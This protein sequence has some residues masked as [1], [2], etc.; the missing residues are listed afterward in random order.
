MPA[1]DPKSAPA[2]AVVVL[3]VTA[4]ENEWKKVADTR[5]PCTPGLVS[6]LLWKC[7]EEAVEAE[8]TSCDHHESACLRYGLGPFNGFILI[9]ERFLP[10]TV[11][12][13]A[14]SSHPAMILPG[15]RARKASSLREK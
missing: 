13:H 4:P 1:A 14:V 12:G 3:G 7:G 9:I 10:R 15:Q 8:P 2:T 6:T 11:E 5:C